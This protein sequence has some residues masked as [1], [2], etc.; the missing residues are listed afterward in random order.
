LAFYLKD[1]ASLFHVYY[2]RVRIIGDDGDL[3]KT[4]LFLIKCIIIVIINGLTLLGI[5]SPDRM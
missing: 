2:N 5:T 4:R 3:T 1:V